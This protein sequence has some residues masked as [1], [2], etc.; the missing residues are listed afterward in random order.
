M[1]LF[2]LLPGP[3][4]G[5]DRSPRATADVTRSDQAIDVVFHVQEPLT[6]ARFTDHGDP[7]YRDS[8]VELFF[9]LTDGTYLNLECSAIGTLLGETG[10]SRAE[11][12]P[13]PGSFLRSVLTVSSL[14][15]T[16]IEIP[17]ACLTWTILISLPHEALE[18]HGLHLSSPLRGNLYKCGDDLPARHYL[19]AFPIP[20]PRPDFHRPEHFGLLEPKAG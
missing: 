14:G 3:W 10:P 19:S 2:H 20:T 6:L 11:R 15:R 1:T 12:R 9:A 7:V 16:P 5:F 4:E 18:G 17:R 13:L 8:C